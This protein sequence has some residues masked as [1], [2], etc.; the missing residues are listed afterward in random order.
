VPPFPND[1]KSA[2]AALPQTLPHTDAVVAAGRAAALV[3]GLATGASALLAAALDDVL[4]VP[5]RSGRI[6][7]YDA[8]VAAA[9]QAGAYGA[10]LSGAGSAILAI[11]PRDR[12][13]AV[14][15]AMLAAWDDYGV[16]AELIICSSAVPGAAV[17]AVPR[18]THHVPLTSQ[19]S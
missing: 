5:F 12:A 16:E 7:G 3:Q 11:A 14:G 8:V 10:T 4:H 17:S 2:R 15:T 19:L 9:K 13:A 1:T 6:P 18:T